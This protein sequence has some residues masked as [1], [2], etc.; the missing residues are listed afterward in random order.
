M[1]SRVP[2][3]MRVK[4]GMDPAKKKIFFVLGIIFTGIVLYGG[5]NI[6]T[7][8]P[9]NKEKI[10]LKIES[11]DRPMAKRLKIVIKTDGYPLNLRSDSSQDS[12]VVGQIPDGTE[13]IV[14]E[15]IDGWYK[16]S[17][18]GKEGWVSKEYTVLKSSGKKKEEKVQTS[19]QIFKGDSYT[20]KYPDQWY[21][22]EY[23][24]Q[25]G[26][27]WVAVSSSQLSSTAPKGDYF[28]PLELRIYSLEEK[29]ETNFKAI[30]SVKK[31]AMKVGG[32]K[33]LKYTFVSPDTSTETNVVEFEYKG[34]VYNFYDNG[35]YLEDLKKVLG[36]FVF[37]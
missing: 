33:A 31:S 23:K 30:K 20:F 27:K 1:L 29:P 37:N 22:S 5:Y 34:K 28:V 36:T 15:E 18:E 14:E 7:H 35:G 16:V 6:K 21:A 12:G 32:V 9:E 24:N 8:L 3:N 19:G 10:P 13:L 11:G 25:D 2:T 26:T 17:Y 4:K